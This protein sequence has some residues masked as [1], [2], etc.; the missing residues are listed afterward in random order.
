MPSYA[1]AHYSAS[2]GAK[3]IQAHLQAE[4]SAVPLKIVAPSQACPIS[5][6]KMVSPWRVLGIVNPKKMVPVAGPLWSAHNHP[7]HATT[8]IVGPAP[9][10]NVYP[11]MS[12]VNPV[13]PSMPPMAAIAVS[14][15]TPE[16]WPKQAAPRWRVKVAAAHPKIVLKHSFAIF[17]TTNAASPSIRRCLAPVKHDLK[18]VT[19]AEPVLVDVTAPF[20]PTT[21]NFKA[22]ERI[23]RNTE[24]V[25]RR[26]QSESFYVAPRGAIAK[27]KCAILA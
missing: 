4:K 6:A 23:T 20:V 24:A 7:I 11:K 21:A 22:L 16:S 13:N 18:P 3:A 2:Q 5:Y 14:V 27:L 1:F 25:S 17:H 12:P 8:S 26:T 9:T 15:P 10:V 19:M